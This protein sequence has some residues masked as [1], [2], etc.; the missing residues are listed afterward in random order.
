M[1]R[2]QLCP[3]IKPEKTITAF[4]RYSWLS[5]MAECEIIYGDLVFRST[6]AF[7]K[8]RRLDVNE[9]IKVSIL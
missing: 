2:F 9:R 6:E 4:K 5:N 7:I 3:F 8:L 1:L